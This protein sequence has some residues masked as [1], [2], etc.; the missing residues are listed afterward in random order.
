MDDITSKLINY[1]YCLIRVSL[2]D[3]PKIIYWLPS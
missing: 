1:Y 3:D 2:Y